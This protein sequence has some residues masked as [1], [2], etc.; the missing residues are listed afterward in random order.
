MKLDWILHKSV[1]PIIKELK[2]INPRLEFPTIEAKWFYIIYIKLY[3][4]TKD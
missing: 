2:V 3:S 1:L 4:Q